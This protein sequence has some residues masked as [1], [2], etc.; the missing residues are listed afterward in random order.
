MDIFPHSLFYF[1]FLTV[2]TLTFENFSAFTL[3]LFCSMHKYLEDD[4]HDTNNNKPII[5][6]SRFLCGSLSTQNICHTD[7]V[8]T[9]LCSKINFCDVFDL[10]K[11]RYFIFK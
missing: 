11:I 9:E 8:A 1:P 4:C 10:T 5:C 3:S 7:Y 6:S 2:N